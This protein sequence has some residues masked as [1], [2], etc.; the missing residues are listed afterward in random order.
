MSSADRASQVAK[1]AKFWWERL[2]RMPITTAEIWDF[3][4][5]RDDPACDAAFTRLEDQT[6]NTRGRFVVLPSPGG[7]SVID[8]LTGEP[9]IFAKAQQ[10]DISV[11]DA[12]GIADILNLRNFRAE[13]N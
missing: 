4:R 9:A 2:G 10:T 11:E 6:P 13:A 5:W 3:A 7:F 12:N 8:T 1:E